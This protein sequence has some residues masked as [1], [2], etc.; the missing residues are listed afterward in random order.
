[1]TTSS[2]QR[3]KN[4]WKQYWI[5]T[6][7]V[8][9][10]REDKQ[11]PFI[12]ETLKKELDITKIE[13][14]LEVGVGYGRVAKAILDTF[15][16][17][18]QYYGIDISKS[19]ILKSKEYCAEKWYEYASGPFMPFVGDFE[20]EELGFLCD[21]VIS[22]ET[23]SAIPSGAEG[24]KT[25][26]K[27]IQKMCSLSKKYVCNLDYI[28]TTHQI[29]NNAHDYMMAYSFDVSEFDTPNNNEKLFICRVK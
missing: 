15:P 25:V 27:W 29:L 2:Q 26:Q 8:P 22:V 11:L 12:I 18:Y 28:N 17:I 16:R 1:L 3:N 5:D 10:T 4:D 6:E 7:L 23:M 24:E 14:V 9:S 13:T 21:L 20:T 19:A